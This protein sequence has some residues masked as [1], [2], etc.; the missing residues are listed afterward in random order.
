MPSLTEYELIKQQTLSFQMI[1]C[2]HEFRVLKGDPCVVLYHI[3]SGKLYHFSD[4]DWDVV[5]KQ[6]ATLY[7]TLRNPPL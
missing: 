5:S 3:K 6:L 2:T 4:P 7:Q 1:G